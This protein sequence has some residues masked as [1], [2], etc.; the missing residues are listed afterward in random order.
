MRNCQRAWVI[1][2]K[3][4]Q[5][6]AANVRPGASVST[7]VINESGTA[8]ITASCTEVQGAFFECIIQNDECKTDLTGE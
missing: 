8:A 4:G 6:S 3:P 7:K 5:G 1:G 2:W